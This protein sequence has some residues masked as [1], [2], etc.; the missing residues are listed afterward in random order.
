MFNLPYKNGALEIN[1]IPMKSNIEYNRRLQA[2]ISINYE[3]LLLSNHVINYKSLAFILIMK[4]M[5]FGRTIVII[6]T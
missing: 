3:A 1:S 5:S 2:I 6:K 4:Y